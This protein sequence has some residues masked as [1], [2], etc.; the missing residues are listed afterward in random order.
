MTYPETLDYLFSQL[1]MYQ[2]IGK[3][4]YKADL[5]STNQLMDLLN[6]PQHRFKSVHIAGTNG[7]GS[8][9][10]LIA[11]VFQ[12]AGY[13]TGLYT[14]PHLVDF[15]E[16]IRIN[17][18]IIKEENVT[19]FVQNHKS[20]FESLNLSFF[21]WTVGL[22]FHHFAKEEVDIAII[23]VGMGG[24]LDSTNIITPELSIITNIGSDH[25]EFLGDTP[26]RIAQEKGGIIKSK[27][28]VVIGRSQRETEGIFRKIA[29]HHD[30][31]IVFADQQMPDDIPR[32]DLKGNYQKENRQ[33]AFI[34]L[35]MLSNNG[36]KIGVDHI[37]IGF[38][39]VVNN[40][41]LRGRWD[42]LQ[43]NPTI[44]CDVAH[45]V[46]GL[47]YIFDQLK[48]TPYH[49]LHLVL[50]FVSDKNVS[51]I[52][53]LLPRDAYL[54]LCQPD[55]PRTM[56]IDRLSKLANE[57]DLQFQDFNSV[58]EAIKAARNKAISDDLIFVGGSTFVVADL[59]K[60][61]AT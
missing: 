39:N 58:S 48:S 51:E 26:A 25:G 19:E 52:L 61:E 15:R 6:N 54:Y 59:L 8:V 42:I 24:R 16:R 40:T 23:E 29:L 45:N 31:A 11:S 53:Q 18:E 41:G 34:A 13:K 17:G 50:G 20:E 28:P 5:D 27:T 14:S 55:I 30:A 7:K 1:P 46:E 21:E 56:P 37:Q 32:S 44:I 9:S 4:A 3:A 43:T 22:A 2:R 47:T 35:E 49:D 60:E 57:A 38:E 36:W 33:T 10:H 12:A